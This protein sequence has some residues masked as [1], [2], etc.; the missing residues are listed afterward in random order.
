MKQ[1][2]PNITK[3]FFITIV[4][5][6]LLSVV[7]LPKGKLDKNLLHFIYSYCIINVLQILLLFSYKTIKTGKFTAFIFS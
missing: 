5:P 1:E 2:S 7:A 4:S 3:T 6:F